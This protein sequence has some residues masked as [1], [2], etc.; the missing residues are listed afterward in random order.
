MSLGFCGLPT[1]WVL[2]KNDTGEII[3]KAEL[4][5]FSEKPCFR[6]KGRKVEINTKRLHHIDI[7]CDTVDIY[8]GDTWCRADVYPI[9]KDTVPTVYNG[10]MKISTF[11]T[12]IADFGKLSASVS[13]LKQ[14]HFKPKEIF[15][16]ERQ[17][18]DTTAVLDTQEEE[19]T[20]SYPVDEVENE[21][22]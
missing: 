1:I 11:V 20:D 21:Q 16:K 8:Y 13:E 17:A 10:W 14:I 22:Q 6:T 2:Y 19:P 3:K 18:S 12:G 15:K 4:I 7:F 9:T 5:D